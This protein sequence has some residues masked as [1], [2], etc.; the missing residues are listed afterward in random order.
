[1]GFALE[2]YWSQA[3]ARVIVPM[4]APH[5]DTHLFMIPIYISPP[6]RD[7]RNKAQLGKLYLRS[8]QPF[9]LNTMNST[10]H[11][12]TVNPVHSASK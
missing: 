8:W 3:I 9:R 6:F 11:H 12:I 7:T 5:I 1:M 10:S 2:V 4:L